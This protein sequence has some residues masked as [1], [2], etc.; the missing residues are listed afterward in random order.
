[1]LASQ[2]LKS[3]VAA[4]SDRSLRAEKLR[5][6]REKGWITPRK[7]VYAVQC[8]LTKLK[9]QLISISYSRCNTPHM[10]ELEHTSMSRFRCSPAGG[11]TLPSIRLPPRPT[12]LD[13][14]SLP[15]RTSTCLP[16]AHNVTT[17]HSSSTPCKQ[18]QTMWPPT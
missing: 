8:P 17:V 13:P 1:L 10:V 4:K 11:R 15:I 9:S 16:K 3:R 14:F 6:N 18:R 2:A 7:R 12:P 5:Y